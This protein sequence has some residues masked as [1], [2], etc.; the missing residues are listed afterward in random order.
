MMREETL[1]KN[2]HERN[3][4]HFPK[5]N[6]CDTKM[7]WRKEKWKFVGAQQKNFTDR[8]MRQYLHVC[9]HLKR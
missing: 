5:K 9:L 6:W 7:K 8:E 2:S 1:K 4:L 3:K